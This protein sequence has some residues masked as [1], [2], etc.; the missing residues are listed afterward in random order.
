MLKAI[1]GFELQIKALRGTGKLG[2][3]KPEEVRARL[4]EALAQQG[5]GEMAALIRSNLPPA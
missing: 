4:A 1:I 5:E 3:D 2:Q